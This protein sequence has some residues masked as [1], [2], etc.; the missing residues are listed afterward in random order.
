MSEENKIEN[1]EEE[2]STA[3]TEEAAVETEPSE[4]EKLRKELADTKDL[5]L[6]TVAEYDNF[7]KRTAKEKIEIYG[8]ATLKAV[9]EILSVIDNFER[10]LAVET[11]DENFKK[12]VSMIFNQYLEI[13]KKLGVSEIKAEGEE[14]NPEFH[15]A[16]QQI[17]DENLGENVVATVF[18]KGYML[19]D[20]VIRPSMVVVA[21]P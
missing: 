9:S 5:Y 6:R 10:A 17:E 4:E 3:E 7:R 16:V 18:Q 2:V 8:D 19:G 21:N 11:S 12:G 1:L 13:L 15:H 14:F 20:K